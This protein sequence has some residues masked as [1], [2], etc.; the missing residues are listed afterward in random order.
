M[1]PYLTS[2]KTTLFSKEEKQASSGKIYTNFGIL[3][4]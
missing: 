1:Q 2:E 3:R 4:R